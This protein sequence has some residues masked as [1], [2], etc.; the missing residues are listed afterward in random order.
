[1]TVFEMPPVSAVF[2]PV[3]RLRDDLVVGYEALARMAVQPYRAPDRWLADASAVGRRAELELVCLAAAT[4]RGL[5]PGDQLL[6]L[7][8]SPSLLADPVVG[9]HLAALAG[10]VVVELSE[11]EPVEDYDALNDVVSEWRERG[12]R[13]AID[14][15][16]AGYASLQ[17]VLRLTPDFIKLDKTLVQGVEHDRSR[18]AL[19]AS[20]VAL[21]RESGAQVIAEGIETRD[22]LAVLHDVGVHLGQGYLL[23]RPDEGWHGAGR[24]VRPLRLDGCHTVAE[25]GEAVCEHLAARGVMPSL[26]LARDGLLRCI[27]Q[28]GLWQI[29]DGL[30]PGAGITGRAYRDDVVVRVDD[31][32]TA[33]GYLEA[34][35]GVVAEACVPIR[36]GGQ[37]VGAL[38][39]D[40]VR[41]LTDA[42]VEELQH[43]AEQVSARIESLDVEPA[44]GAL[45]RL[46]AANL[47]LE[48]ARS[49]DDIVNVVL[50]AALQMTGLSSAVLVQPGDGDAPDVVAR[51]P[52]GVELSH[53]D[54]ADL[55]VAGRSCYSASDGAAAAMSGADRL[56]RAGVRTL[57]LVPLRPANAPSWLL[58]IADVRR[59]Q[60]HTDTIELLELL[61]AQAAARIETVAYIGELRRRASE[62]VLTGL[63][64]RAA[65]G[66][67]LAGWEETGAVVLLD[68]DHFKQIND[69]FGHLEGDRVLTR[70]GALF[71]S[72]VRPGDG[73]YRLGG[74]EFAV[75]L[76]GTDEAAASEVGAR[77]ELA[78]AAAL[79]PYQA[80]VSVGVAVTASSAEDALRLA[81][82]RLYAAK[83][84]SAR[85]RSVDPVHAP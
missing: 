33:E 59:R 37:A 35:P 10:R 50:D 82:R 64:N 12:V 19:V 75:L 31:V 17:H 65:F 16:G 70:L 81:D 66:E 61:A 38:N 6:F 56:R 84:R 18:R 45:A 48:A 25:V 85:R 13:L 34:I 30:E 21:A 74:D 40:S 55:P 3:M 60:L 78:G 46:V 79:A 62:D 11:Q 71:A 42:D 51:G 67:A 27:A 54:V 53:G 43:C 44:T 26:Y 77:L 2:Q 7:N 58:A 52:L 20:F 72:V 1:M 41:P 49:T 69:T 24:A 23:G 15:T 57:V 47:R 83:H 76:P 14:D 28:R 73:V 36:A 8:L 22:Q 5:P 32:R 80:G 68:V 4:A 29:L 39:I 9:E 63:G